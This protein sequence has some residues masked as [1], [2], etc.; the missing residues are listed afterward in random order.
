MPDP[1]PA[2][3]SPPDLAVRLGVSVR[4][5]RYWR[6]TGTGPPFALLGRHIRY[7]LGD[8][9]TWEQDRRSAAS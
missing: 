6:S 3:I 9:T 4:T 8:L 2:W 5:L 7:G 1:A